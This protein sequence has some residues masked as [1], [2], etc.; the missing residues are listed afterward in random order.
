MT[1][2]ELLSSIYRYPRSPSL[3]QPNPSSSVRLKPPSTS[4]QSPVP[5]FST[6]ALAAI[7]AKVKTVCWSVTS[8]PVTVS[9]AHAEGDRAQY[10]PSSRAAATMGS[11]TEGRLSFNRWIF[12]ELVL[13]TSGLVSSSKR[14]SSDSIHT[15][16]LAVETSSLLW[17]VRSWTP[18]CTMWRNDWD[19]LALFLR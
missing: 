4:F 18:W 7:W 3:S 17:S 8:G 15:P 10:P 9:I 5:G 1:I 16:D 12:M 13:T 2:V 14:P 19:E 11:I 6:Y